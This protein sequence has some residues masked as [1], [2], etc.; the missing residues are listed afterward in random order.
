MK[1]STMSKLY[2]KKMHR[3]AN[4][5]QGKHGKGKIVEKDKRIVSLCKLQS[6]IRDQCFMLSSLHIVVVLLDK[7][8][9]KPY[10]F[11]HG[12]KQP[13]IYPN[14]LKNKNFCS[15]SSLIDERKI[16]Y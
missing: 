12:Q 11:Y 16:E 5:T 13:K 8:Y 2:I 14:I 10:L 15:R 9:A 6:W 1:A 4:V 7:Y 3:F